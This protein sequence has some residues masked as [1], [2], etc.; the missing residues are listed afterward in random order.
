MHHPA[1]ARN[2]CA[3]GLV[4]LALALMSN[5]WRVRSLQLGVTSALTTGSL[6]A[7]KSRIL[8]SPHPCSKMPPVAD[9]LGPYPPPALN[10]QSHL[11]S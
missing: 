2:C 3:C 11:S 10:V 1:S 5:L 7:S 8:R 4:Q 9:S 6:A